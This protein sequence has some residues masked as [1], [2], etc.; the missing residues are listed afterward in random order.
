[1]GN[2]LRERGDIPDSFAEHFY[3]Q[4]QGARSI[5]FVDFAGN[6]VE[7]EIITVAGARI[8]EFSADGLALTTGDVRIDVSAALTPAVAAPAF[9]TAVNGDTSAA[10]SAS[11]LA[12]NI[13]ALY[14]DSNGVTA[15]TLT[16]SSALVV[17]S[18]AA[19]TGGLAEAEKQM[20]Y[21]TYT[22]TAQDV[23]T[24]GT[25]AGTANI[26]IGVGTFEDTPVLLSF[27][28]RDTNH[29][30]RHD[31]VAGDV[32]VVWALITGSLYELTVNDA[33]SGATPLAAGDVITW[34]AIG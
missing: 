28:V 31:L 17:V 27:L 25:V 18:A 12:D 26:P 20:Q 23:T 11:L 19:F 24:L 3:P 6:C 29:H 21:G 8:Y 4:I 13:V 1:M 5:A 10:W 34:S 15:M 22:V 2:V 9:V 33:D 7:D 30:I 16:T 14:A 32:A